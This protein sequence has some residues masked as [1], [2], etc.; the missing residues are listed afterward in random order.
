MLKHLKPAV[1][2]YNLQLERHFRDSQLLSQTT[3]QTAVLR[4]CRGQNSSWRLQPTDEGKRHCLC[5]LLANMFYVHM[6][7]ITEGKQWTCFTQESRIGAGPGENPEWRM[8]RERGQTLVLNTADILFP[9]IPTKGINRTVYATPL[10]L[11]FLGVSW[12]FISFLCSVWVYLSHLIV[13]ET[14]AYHSR[15]AGKVVS[16]INVLS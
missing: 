2:V 16:S 13:Y 7:H 9:L 5:Q 15:G 12:C 11:W 1:S 14:A 10:G 6:P 4:S 3:L 8:T